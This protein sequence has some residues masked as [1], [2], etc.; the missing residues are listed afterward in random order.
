MP[1]CSEFPRMVDAGSPVS[2]NFSSRQS[3][4]YSRG[5]GPNGLG[6]RSAYGNDTLLGTTQKGVAMAYVRKKRTG[7]FGNYYYQLV[8]SRRV[9][10]QPRQKVLLHLGE[11]HT[12]DAALKKWPRKI[13]KL[14]GEAARL[15]D[16]VPAGFEEAW[17]MK[18]FY[19]DNMKRAASLENQAHHLE[20]K[21]ARL[22]A[23]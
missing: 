13:K 5:P 1:S 3:G 16:G 9:D 8:E 11:H 21:R 22:R 20:D 19:K 23:F 7:S 12:V 17:G 14:L 6:L 15:R 18:T 4:E 2:E 10:G